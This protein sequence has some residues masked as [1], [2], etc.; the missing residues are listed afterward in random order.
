[1]RIVAI[2]LAVLGLLGLFAAQLVDMGFRRSATFVQLI[3]ADNK[4]VGTP[5]FIR[6]PNDAPFVKGTGPSGS[7]FLPVKAM[8]PD[9]GYVVI[10]SFLG[11]AHAAKI[12][13][14]VVILLGGLGWWFETRLQRNLKLAMIP[15]EEEP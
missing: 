12:G 9:K 11:I 2:A 6:T 14:G 5:I 3:D 15:Y 1:M 7:K 13:A 8:E 10:D 4:L